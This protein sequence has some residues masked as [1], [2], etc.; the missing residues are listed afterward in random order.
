MP[1]FFDS[2]VESGHM[3]RT[4]ILYQEVARMLYRR[5]MYAVLCTSS[6]SLVFLSP[7][8]ES[9]F[10]LTFTLFFFKTLHTQG[11]DK[12]AALVNFPVFRSAEAFSLVPKV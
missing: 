10:L 5:V 11:P 12:H 3:S 2:M 8:K 6:G 7:D 4:L 1:S 9:L